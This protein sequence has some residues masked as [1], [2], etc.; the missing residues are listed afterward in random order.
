MKREREFRKA[1]KYFKNVS[2]VLTVLK[3]KVFF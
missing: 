1:D 2:K 3:F